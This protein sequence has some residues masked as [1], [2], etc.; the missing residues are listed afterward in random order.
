MI[1]LVIFGIGC[2]DTAPETLVD[3]L[4]VIASVAEPPEVR[5]DTTFSYE[6]YFA[7]PDEADAIAMSWVCTNLGSGCLEA[8][9]GA[10]S[11]V[12]EPLEGS[13]PIWSR[14]LSVS[15][16]L[17]GIVQDEAITATQLWTLYCTQDTC[18]VIDDA[19]E[20]DS[21]EPWPEALRDDLANPTSWMADLP[22]AGVSLAYQLLTTSLSDTPHQNPTLTPET[23]LP[24]SLKRDKTFSIDVDVDGNFSAQAQLYNYITGGGF[25]NP[26][27]FVQAGDTVSLEGTAPKKG[28][29]ARIWIVLVD[30]SGGMAVWTEEFSLD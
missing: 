25:K 7:N 18:P 5:P 8:E 20:L 17:M 26:S 1:A 28:G 15:P 3:E 24:T 23:D 12:I 19:A 22:M 21:S 2:G 4:R 16:S 27:T 10:Q 9:G 6:T 29:K 11:I 14:S 13:A 30:G